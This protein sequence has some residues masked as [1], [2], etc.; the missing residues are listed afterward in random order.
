MKEGWKTARGN[1]DA[2]LKIISLG[3]G[4]QS[5]AVY[6]MSSIGH[7]L[8]RADYAVFADPGAEHKKTYEILEWLKV[9]ESKNNGIPIIINDDRNLYEDI[10][11]K[12][13][14]GE[15]VASIPARSKNNEGLIMRQCTSEYKIQPVIKSTREL[16][17]L[18]PRKRMK[19]TEIWL[20]ISTDEIQRMKESTLYNVNYFYPLI[21]H[22]MSRSDCM[23]FFKKNNF[24]IPV[25]S[26][27]VFCPF[28]S[29]KFWLD[30]KRENSSAWKMS[31]EVDKTI[32]NHPRLKEKLYWHK[33]CVPLDEVEL[34]E[35]QLDLFIEECEGYCGL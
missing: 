15:R 4:V 13:K 32:R 20:G 10:M 33:S 17:G 23:D 29:D 2:E 27:C 7:K 5:T 22:S 28:H 9:W 25:K 12:Y 24:P 1:K 8:P 26:S 3:L 16:H 31:V 11:T 18:K 14:Q 34:S 21:Y 19:P 6:L 30:I 35:D